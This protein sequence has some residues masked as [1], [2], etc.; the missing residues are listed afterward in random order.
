MNLLLI[1]I[2]VVAVVLLITGGFC[3]PCSFYSGWESFWPSSP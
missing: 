2:V 1:I 3:S